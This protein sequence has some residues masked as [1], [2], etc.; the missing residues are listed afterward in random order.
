[1]Y[2]DSAHCPSF[3]LAAGKAFEI[4]EC[5]VVA[6]VALLKFVGYDFLLEV[7]RAAT[8]LKIVALALHGNIRTTRNVV[9]SL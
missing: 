5:D 3:S 9:A 4:E 2:I 1:M 8:E 7:G 6:S